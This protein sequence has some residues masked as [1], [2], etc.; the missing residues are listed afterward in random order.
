LFGFEE[1]DDFLKVG[2]F[3]LEGGDFGSEFFVLGGEFEELF[4][5]GACVFDEMN[6]EVVAEDG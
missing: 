3:V 1:G 2:D 4:F 5:G 6:E